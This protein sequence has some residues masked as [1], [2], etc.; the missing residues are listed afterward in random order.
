MSD[1]LFSKHNINRSKTY[2]SKWFLPIKTDCV[3]QQCGVLCV[4]R[5]HEMY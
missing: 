4:Y 2:Y 1:D 5:E 3:D